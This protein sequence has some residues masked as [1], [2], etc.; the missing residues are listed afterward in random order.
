M[1]SPSKTST[2]TWTR[3][4]SNRES[5]RSARRSAF[6]IWCRL[7][8]SRVAVKDSPLVHSGTPQRCCGHCR[9]RAGPP[10]SAVTPP[11][12]RAVAPRMHIM[13]ITETIK[14]ACFHRRQPAPSDCPA[15]PHVVSANTSA[16]EI[17]SSGT[18]TAVTVSSGP[19]APIRRYDPPRS[20]RYT[21]TTRS[22]WSTIQYSVTPKRS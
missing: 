10:T 18:A 19:K 15:P 21:S 16:R 22:S 20:R 7:E 1:A 17:E 12:D 14:D 9:P 5:R 6:G 8:A 13:A 3:W 4:A 2:S 11:T